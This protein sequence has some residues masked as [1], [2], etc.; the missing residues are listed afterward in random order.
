M[1]RIYV[2]FAFISLSLH[3][4]ATSYYVD[5]AKGNDLNDGRSPQKA[6]STFAPLGTI[7]FTAG[8]SILLTGGQRHRGMLT[9]ESVSGSES[10]PIVLTSL[11]EL[12]AT[13][14][15][16]GEPNGILV[17]NCSH[18]VVENIRVTANGGGLPDGV[19]SDG[20]FGVLITASKKGI[21]SDITVRKVEV[22][23]VYYE[24]PGFMRSQKETQNDKLNNISKYGWGIRIKYTDGEAGAQLDGITVEDCMVTNVSHSGIRFTGT[25]ENKI[26]NIRVTRNKVINVGGPGIQ[27]ASMRDAYFAYNTVDHSGS[28]SESRNWKRGS[29]LWT[30][31]ADNVLIE[32]NSFTN[33]NGPMDS[34]GAHI[35]YNC[36]NVVLQYNFSAWNAGGFCEILGDNYNCAYRY[37]ISVNDGFRNGK[38]LTAGQEGKT[39][40]LS[41]YIGGHGKRSG[42]FNCYF[43]NNTIYVDSEIQAKIAIENTSSGALIANNIFYIE[44]NTKTVLGDQYNPEKADGSVVRN[45]VIKNNL[46][47]HEGSWPADN[48]QDSRPVYGDPDFAKK[49]GMEL[50]DYIPSNKELIK[51]GIEIEPLPED[52][53]GL[54]IGLK[55]EHDI[56]GNTIKGKPSFGA[57]QVN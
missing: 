41:G 44:G 56:L 17:S 49:G 57:I 33:A 38:Q 2:Y 42:P 21:F 6:F 25:R 50:T 36:N 40:W 52:S 32:Y 10:K 30:W 34:A 22:D 15:A 3:T 14:D 31:G 11:D 29:G 37:N 19:V 13:I 48:I 4:M 5:A 54:S 51:N 55:V 8:D 12:K 26:S 27:G 16:K 43:Y 24:E 53:I 35:D 39:L 28:I 46:F 9:L 20:R 45:I 7:G 1:K 47:L 18:V 23:S